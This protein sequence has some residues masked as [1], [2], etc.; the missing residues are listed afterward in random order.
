MMLPSANTARAL[1]DFPK[2][3]ARASMK[4]AK[5]QITYMYRPVNI[6]GAWRVHLE[7]SHKLTVTDQEARQWQLF[8]GKFI[9]CGE[10]RPKVGAERRQAVPHLASRRRKG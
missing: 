10:C 6:P 5:V 2:K 7:C 1:P 4:Y 8:I 9:P 3:E